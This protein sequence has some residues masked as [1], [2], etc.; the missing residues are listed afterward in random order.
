MITYISRN[1]K[2]VIN[3]NR[4]IH[5]LHITLT[6][7]RTHPEE[8]HDFWEF[9]YLESGEAVAKSDD[10][11]VHLH[12]GD[13]IFHRPNEIHTTRIKNSTSAKLHC[14]SF[15]TNSKT[16]R[17]FEKRHLTLPPELRSLLNEMFDIADRTFR[18][19]SDDKYVGVAIS[20]TA[21][22]GGQQLYK[23]FLEAFLIKLIHIIENETNSVTY[24][25]K[26]DFEKIV[27]HNIT[28]KLSENVYST[29]S[30]EE[31]CQKMNYSKTY[32]STLFRK[33]SGTSIMQYYHTLK[34]SEAKRLLKQTDYPV[35]TISEML[36][37]NTPY[38]FSYAFKKQEGVAPSEYRNKRERQ[39][40]E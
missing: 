5:C 6:P 4:I 32:L 23:N 36:K 28:E 38:Y 37:F 18:D 35:S 30:V 21:P 40:V 24:G 19:N 31:L 15:K 10:D 25:S 9:A 33:Y 1:L 34:I 3:I 7:Y 13:I 29:M 2:T 17:L 12:A 39:T 27:F 20:E 26:E 14:V 8:Y 16:M 11:F 22:T